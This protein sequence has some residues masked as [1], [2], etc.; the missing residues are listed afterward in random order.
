MRP[1]SLY[2]KP[3][4]S[5]IILGHQ[6]RGVLPVWFLAPS[7]LSLVSLFSFLVGTPAFA[8]PIEL[9]PVTLGSGTIL[10]PGQSGWVSPRQLKLSQERHRPW[11]TSISVRSVFVPLEIEQGISKGKSVLFAFHAINNELFTPS[12]DFGEPILP[13]R[14]YR[15]IVEVRQ[16]LAQNDRPF[17]GKFWGL[18]GGW[19]R[20]DNQF[21]SNREN[22]SG[23]IVGQR[24]SAIGG[25]SIGYQIV[26]HSGLTLSSKL[27]IGVDVPLT[28]MSTE[29][30]RIDLQMNLRVDAKFGVSIGYTWFKPAR[31]RALMLKPKK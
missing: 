13:E 10:Y 21:F 15:A 17:H 11:Q 27:N 1:T 29:G 2:R 25:A 9:P 18:Y 24:H 6:S 23:T 22:S 14:K 5:A 20:I 26:S 4:L 3:R 7:F 31:P 8:Q 12:S 16:Y 30:S 28:A 19:R